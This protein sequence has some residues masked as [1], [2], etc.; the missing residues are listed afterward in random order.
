MK[1]YTKE[2]LYGILKVGAGI[3]FVYGLSATILG[4]ALISNT[5]AYQEKSEIVNAQPTA[6]Y[7]QV[8]NEK[9]D[10]VKNLDK[11][12]MVIDQFEKSQNQIA[13]AEQAKE[14][15]MNSTAQL[16]AE[17][18]QENKALDIYRGVMISGLA[19]LTFSFFVAGAS[20]L[21][22]DDSEFEIL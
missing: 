16:K 17:Y 22:E 10:L 11:E 12:A 21:V 1:E 4:A 7:V 15:Y 9:D 6:E 19:S 20:M 18:S 8:L 2:I 5:E 14:K 13:N 3:T